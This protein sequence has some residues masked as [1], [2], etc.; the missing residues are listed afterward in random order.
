MCLRMYPTQSTINT[1]VC[2]YVFTTTQCQSI[3]QERQVVVAQ[4]HVDVV[5]GGG[6]LFGCSC[7]RVCV[8]RVDG[9]PTPQFLSIG[10]KNEWR[11]TKNNY[12]GTPT[13]LIYT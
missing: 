5:V 11:L 7:S 1:Q 9:I 12:V 2:M 10:L 4:T 3:G 8:C 13:A 6:T